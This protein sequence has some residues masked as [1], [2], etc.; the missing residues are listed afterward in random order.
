MLGFIKRWFSRSKQIRTDGQ[1]MNGP[2][3]MGELY[4][5]PEEIRDYGMAA[6]YASP[7]LYHTGTVYDSPNLV[8]YDVPSGQ[9]QREQYVD[10]FEDTVYP[11][12]HRGPGSIPR[13]DLGGIVT[14]SFSLTDLTPEAPKQ[15]LG[16]P[17]GL[18]FL[19]NKTGEQIR[20]SDPVMTIGRGAECAIVLDSKFVSVL[21]AALVFA[22]GFWYIQDCSSTNG[23]KLN[24][25]RLTPGRNY[26]LRPQDR[27][28]FARDDEVFTVLS[29]DGDGNV[30]KLE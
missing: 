29:H 18:R 25:V 2:Y 1:G 9:E 6:L 10:L 12:N 8:T 13:C 5:S 23:T 14:G 7:E 26:L 17:E 27:I 19:Y 30:V 15:R 11:N 28:I 24:G 22:G 21:H 20:A 4:A 3:E 16:S